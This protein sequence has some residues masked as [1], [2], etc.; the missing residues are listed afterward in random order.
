MSI[1]HDDNVKNPEKYM[2]NPVKALL[3]PPPTPDKLPDFRDRIRH[4]INCLSME[5]GSN[6][7]DWI[8][9]K[10]LTDCLKA[11]DEATNFREGYYGRKTGFQPDS[12]EQK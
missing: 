2:A 1:D 5:N 8:L 4:E 7:P 6:T 11:F 10:Y 3:D 9:A 12:K